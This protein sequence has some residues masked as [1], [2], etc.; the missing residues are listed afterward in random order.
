MPAPVIRHPLDPTGVNVNNLVMNE[1]HTLPNRLVRVISPIYG[2][3]FTES[4]V[5]RDTAN[6]QVLTSSQYDA[7][8]LFEVPT[9]KYGKEICGIILIKDTTVSANVTLQYQ[10]LGGDYGGSLDIIVNMLNNLALDNRPAAW[11]SIIGKPSE[12]PPSHHLHDIGNVYGFEFVV[13][14]LER[15]RRAIEFGDELSHDAIY[16]YIDSVMGDGGI[17][18]ESIA[19]AINDAI[20][21]HNASPSAHGTQIA[22]AVS[23]GISAHTSATDPHPK[24]TEALA[25]HVNSL[26]TADEVYFMSQLGA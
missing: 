18:P 3:F 26:P 19:Q 22:Q 13:H 1:A 14:Q 6:N 23:S 20:A 12:F 8:E 5:I 24:Y 4:V 15:I 9:A 17:S 7:V 25:A 21:A 2:A 10:A 16:K 11:G